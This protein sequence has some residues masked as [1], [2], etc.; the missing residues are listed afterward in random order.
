M[1]KLK[2]L[3][4]EKRGTCW[5]GYSQIGMKK[6]GN[7]MVPNCVKNEEKISEKKIKPMQKISKKEWSKI[8]KF[9]KHIGQDGTYY[10]MQL[11][12]K[13]TALVPVFVEGKL[14][15]KEFI[16]TVTIEFTRDN[17][18]KGRT[19]VKKFKTIA[20][21]KKYTRQMNKKYKLKRQKGFWGNPVNGIEL[22][23]NFS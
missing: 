1:I 18:G 17:R 5:K 23:H 14:T 20:D 9:N 3:I 12:N 10:V 11:T 6:K 19:E 2:D 15:E 4:F 13:G 7:K 22:F 21:A 8:K 16:P